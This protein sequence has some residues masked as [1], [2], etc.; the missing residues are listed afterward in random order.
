MNRQFVASTHAVFPI[1]PPFPPKMSTTLDSKWQELKSTWEVEFSP[2][3]T[4]YTLLAWNVQLLQ[5]ILLVDS[6]LNP[7]LHWSITEFSRFTVVD[8]NSP[9]SMFIP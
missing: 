7:L 3:V 9:V 2:T 5:D 6:T 4:P 8:I 1:F